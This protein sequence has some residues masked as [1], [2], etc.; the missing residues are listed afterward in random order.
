VNNLDPRL[1]RLVSTLGV[2]HG[3]ALRQTELA[4]KRL[5][6]A[7]AAAP[8]PAK[9]A[10]LLKRVV[11][12]LNQDAPPHDL[13]DLQWIRVGERTFTVSVP[14]DRLPALDNR[15]EIKFVEAAR[16]MGPCLVT[17]LPET[18]ADRVH[19]PPAPAQGFTGTGVIVGI[20]DFGCDFTLDDF[21]DPTT[22]QTRIEFFWDQ[23][24]APTAGEGSPV[25]F[26]YGVEYSRAAINRALQ[27]SNPFA[28]VRHNPEPGSHGTHVLGIA[29][30]NG[31]TADRQFAAGHYIGAA[32]DA[33]II[34][35][36]PAFTS[37]SEKVTDST[38]VA[39]AVA[40]V[41]GKAQTL[42]RPC[43][44]NMSLGQNGGSHDGESLVERAIDRWLE[45]PERAFVVAGG[46][47]HVWRGHASGRLQ[48]GQVRS[49][50]WQVGGGLPLPNGTA[51]PQ[52][53]D[54]TA[55]ELEI[56]YSSQ[57]RFRVRVIDPTGE[58]VGPVDPGAQPADKPLASGNQVY[59]DSARF[60]VLN[61]ESRVYVEI[62]PGTRLIQGT[63]IPVILSGVWK[64]EVEL[65]EGRDGR[66]DVWIE[67]DFRDP[68]NRFGD[69]SFFGRDGQE[70]DFDPTRTL[71]TPATGRRSIV[72]ANYD[73]AARPKA[74]E[75]SSGR[76]STRDG[77]QKPEVAAPGTNIVSSHALA[78]R[79]VD[80]PGTGVHPA[81]LPMTGTSM[82]AP[83]V[84]G[85][86]AL[87]L[88][89]NRR[90]SAAQ[91]TRILIAATRPVAGQ[92]EP[93]DPAWGY[94]QLDAK[95]AVDLVQ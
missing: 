16:A 25:G 56:W 86:I 4:R 34:F 78:G 43:V 36:Q 50:R 67:R 80:P 47:E 30:G 76:G 54:R 6:P 84:A 19:R 59:I 13:A 93:F 21:R 77:R 35:V 60:T 37:P 23:S 10:D 7:A 64:I 41:F 42:G 27:Q 69:Q 68:E 61:G 58:V 83:H 52:R 45:E 29:T 53:P 55:N 81:R 40:Y 92:Q 1:S 95:R 65:L 3:A 79:P 71:G 20:I 46:N 85:V 24:F 66:Y 26:G 94:G 38:H 33:T 17:S 87:M 89:K 72:V 15:P 70:D 2:A 63:D 28:A 62:S 12:L 90:L 51:L 73:H 8:D 31:R 49:L 57:D 48:P 39:D 91:I 22:G 44:I 32:P 88:E 14:L 74:P 18:R 11:V 75:M 5:I 9:P 82:A